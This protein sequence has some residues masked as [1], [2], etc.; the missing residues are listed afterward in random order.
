MDKFGLFELLSKL[1]Y[2]KNNDSPLIN[3]LNGLISSKN[4]ENPKKMGDG[5]TINEPPPYYKSDAILK[6]ISRHN[7][8]SKQIDKNNKSKN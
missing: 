5:V 2:S 1:S 7:E 3:I 6:I 4:K 8:I